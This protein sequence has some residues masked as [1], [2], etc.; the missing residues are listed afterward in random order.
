MYNY[1]EYMQLPAEAI[2]RNDNI[3]I[4]NKTIITPLEQTVQDTRPILQQGKKKGKKEQSLS[5]KKLK[6]QEIAEKEQ[7]DL[8]QGLETISAALDYTS[9]SYWINQNGGNLNTAQALGLDMVTYVALGGLPGLTKRGL[10]T[11]TKKG[12]K[13]APNLLERLPSELTQAD[14]KRYGAFKITTQSLPATPLPKGYRVPLEIEVSP[15]R[16]QLINYYYSPEYKRRLLKAGFSEQEASKRVEALIR[17]TN[18]QVL[19]KDLQG[20][21]GLTEIDITSPDLVHIYIDGSFSEQERKAAILEELVHASE[22]RGLTLQEIMKN[23]NYWKL[24]DEQKKTI[25][26]ELTELNNTKAAAYNRTLQ[27]EINQNITAEAQEYFKYP[28]ET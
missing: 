7:K 19:N 27:P 5:D 23:P 9:P 11:L 8:Q 15:I 20:A 21:A 1:I 17:N 25:I 22:L 4:V 12:I 28:Y 14:L 6:Q 24:S 18:T 3:A 16:E 2:Q 26:T 13:A 10:V